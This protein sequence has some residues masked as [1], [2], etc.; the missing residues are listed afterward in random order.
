MDQEERFQP[1]EED[2]KLALREHAKLRGMEARHKYGEIGPENLSAL[3]KDPSVVRF[4]TILRFDAEPLEP[5]EFAFPSPLGEKP[6]DGYCLF[7]HPFFQDRPE[8]LP[9]LVS[10]QLVRINYGE[11]ATH[12]DAEAFGAALLGLD[13]EEYYQEICRLADELAAQ[14]A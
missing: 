12:E 6:G 10:Y 11:V 8:A 4:P 9:F 5:G 13:Q 2:G 1:T 14:G 7:V 3:L